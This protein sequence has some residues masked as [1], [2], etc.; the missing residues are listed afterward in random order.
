MNIDVLLSSGNTDEWR[1]V[2][3][4]EVADTGMLIVV[5]DE[6]IVCMYAPG[7]WMKVELADDAE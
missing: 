2:A 1:D 7:M 6:T 5:D 3:R 4:Y